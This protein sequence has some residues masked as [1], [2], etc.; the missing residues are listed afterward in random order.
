MKCPRCQ[1]E[2][3]TG[4]NFCLG[5]GA[6]FGISCSSCSNE[7]PPGSQF[8][9]KCG[10]PVALESTGQ[11]RFSSPESYT[12]K[13]LAEKILTSKAALEGER[14]QV[15][16]LFA[17]LKGSMELL[18]DRDPEEARKILDPVLERMMDAVHHYE[19][20][21]NQVMGDEIMALFGAPLAHEDHAVRAC[22]AALRMQE[23]VKRYAEEVQHTAG[24]PVQIRVGLNS[25]DVVVRSIGSDLRMDYTAVGQTTHLAARME[26]AA[27]PGSILT[28]A[29]TLRLAEGYVEA[30]ALGPIPIKGLKEPIGVYEIT[31][32]APVRSR[33]QA[34]ATRQLSPFVGRSAEMEEL[35]RAL[36]RAGTGHGQVVAVVAEPG[37]GKSRLFYEFLRADLTRD[38]MPLES[39]SLSYGRANAYLPVIDLLKRYFAVEVADSPAEIRATIMNRLRSLDEALLSAAPVLLSLLDLPGDDALWQSLDPGER[40]QRTLDT[41]LRLFLRQSQ[42]QPLV[43][44]I[45]NLHWVDSA[46]QELLDRLVAYLPSARILLLVNFRPEYQHGWA[47]KRY[48]TQLR[49]DPLSPESADELLERLLGSDAALRPLKRLLVDHTGGNPFFLE[50]SVRAL[51]ETHMLVGG[52]GAYCIT[53]DVGTLHVPASVQAVLAA[54]I[55]RLPD[56]SKQILQAAAV[57]GKDFGFELLER[58]AGLTGEML[59]DGLAHLQAT[60]FVHSTTLFPEPEYTFKHA[61]THQVAYA[62]LLHHRRRVLHSMVLDAL[63]ELPPGRMTERIEA[64][65]HHAVQGELWERALPHLRQAARKAFGRSAQQEAV[66]WLEGS[67]A[68]LRHLPR[69]PRTLE[70]GIDV[71]IELRHALW[72]LG[73]FSRILSCLLEAEELA[74]SLADQ[75]RLARIAV[76]KTVS[77]YAMGDYGAATDSVGHV[78]TIGTALDDLPL[79]IEATFRLGQIRHTTGDYARAAEVLRRTS[80][81]I[82]H[83]LVRERFGMAFLPSVFCRTYL[84]WCLAETGD[85][86][87]GGQLA[88]EAVEIAEAVQHPYSLAFALFGAA[89]L[90]VRQGALQ[91]ATPLL[92]RARRIGE[93][94]HLPVLLNFIGELLGYAYAL[95]GRAREGADLLDEAVKQAVTIGMTPNHARGVTWLTEALLI[96]GHPTE[97]R[98]QAM[99]ALEVAGS[100]GEKGVHA[101]VLRLLGKIMATP[102]AF[103]ADASLEYY[104]GAEALG[105]ELGMRPLVAHC[106]LDLGKL[107]QRTGK[108]DQA[109]EHLTT[110]TT[111]YREMDMRFWLEQAE[112]E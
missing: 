19:G 56:S 6:R 65:A 36:I 67:L 43:A 27:P 82:T 103:D 2:N 25:G 44:V 24:V 85:F 100:R 88:E 3:P 7:L 39:S 14:K 28:T 76:Y 58:I 79:R 108:R 53:G 84:I 8:C 77:L 112:I 60:E 86:A 55:D 22:Y 40:R 78:L 38:W 37:V 61:L 111:M 42:A 12:P 106:H 75:Q 32:T 64:L 83:D 52:R 97:A 18:A 11:S 90:A 50:E 74:V 20:T 95:S 46:T 92:E 45:E 81:W 93:E 23:S 4:S 94:S 33:L 104:R 105:T 5:C 54:R 26:Q 109:R 98:Q 41:L 70:E 107:Y 101:H 9:N 35:R 71:R 66:T 96:A 47:S 13:H 63:E 10:T 30:S 87:E 16:V 80:S 31:G 57:I 34:F 15:T 69:S 110:A 29:E 1:H 91:R 49:L 17:D 51:I 68:A 62:S 102:Q 73:E 59:R 21:V 99:L 89:I 72:P 48:Y